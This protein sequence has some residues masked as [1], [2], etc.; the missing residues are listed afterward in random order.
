MLDLAFTRIWAAMHKTAGR[1]GMHGSGIRYRTVA[2]VK[3]DGVH[4]DNKGDHHTMKRIHQHI[5][6][7][8]RR[9]RRLVIIAASL[10]T[11]AIAG[12]AASGSAQAAVRAPTHVTAP[13]VEYRCTGAYRSPNRSCYFQTQNAAAPVFNPS[14]ILAAI[15]PPNDK[16]LVTCYY[17]KSSPSNWLSDGYQD[18]VVWTQYT[19]S[20]TGHIPDIYLD[21]GGKNPWDPPYYLAA[22][23]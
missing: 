6:G 10:S 11:I 21:K 7:H 15:L 16:V 14:G 23:A 18:H 4:D 3:T 19:N 17:R 22:C 13:S 5:E 1:T 12:L 8:L 9:F 20:I 2:P